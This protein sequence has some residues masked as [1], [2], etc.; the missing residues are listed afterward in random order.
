MNI[1]YLSGRGRTT[2]LVKIPGRAPYLS[3]R[4]FEEFTDI[5]S[6]FSVRQG[7]V[8]SGIYE[9]MNLALNRGDDPEKVRKNFEIIGLSLG[10]KTD[11]MVY[12]HQTHTV[13]VM[14]VGSEH[15]GMGI[16]RERDFCDVD[17]LITNEPGICLVTGHADC[18]PLYFF[19]RKNKAIGLAHSGWKGSANDIA[20]NMIR[21]MHEEFA[22]DPKD[23][24]A[25]IGPGI[26]RDHYEVGTDVEE[27]FE[28]RYGEV[29]RA[30]V[31]KKLPPDGKEQKYLLNLHMANYYNMTAAGMEMKDIYITDV[32]TYCNPQL[33][34]SHRY[35]KGQRG[36]MCAFLMLKKDSVSP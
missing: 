27:Q 24:T 11:C 9:S 22:T 32:C 34:F 15:K 28:N 20:G 33:L 26:C 30:H 21:K 7:G 3:I 8:S 18:L 35:T 14:R 12:A 19:D 6:A 13:N 31:L 1:N 5:I 29:K 16:T 2:D 10:I 36:G 17:G 25:F 23:L 4:P